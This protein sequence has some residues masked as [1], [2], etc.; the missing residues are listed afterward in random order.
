MSPDVLAS[1]RRQ[2]TGAIDQSSETPTHELVRNMPSPKFPNA[3]APPDPLRCGCWLQGTRG[4]GCSIDTA[5]CAI[6]TK[7]SQS[8]NCK[9]LWKT[10]DHIALLVLPTLPCRDRLRTVN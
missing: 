1:I 2:E 3:H 4:G 6:S 8:F 5:Y 7:A 9:K 10:C